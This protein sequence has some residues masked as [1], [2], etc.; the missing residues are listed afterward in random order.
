MGKIKKIKK[1]E[2]CITQPFVL[3]GVI[4]EEDGKFLLVQEEGKWNLPLGWVELGEDLVSAAEREGR[5]ETGL[6]LEV[7]DFLGVY[8]VVKKRAGKVLHMIKFIFTA[9]RKGESKK[10]SEGLKRK[11]FT[12]DEVKKLKNKKLLWHPEV[13]DQLQDYKEGKRS[14]LERVSY[15]IVK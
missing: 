8:T 10:E 7:K 12:L 13:V 3:A 15:F 2:H 9:E 14:S 11:K 6:K 1:E 4:V 5:E